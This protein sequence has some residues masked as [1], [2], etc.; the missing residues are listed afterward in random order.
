[1]SQTYSRA[2][3]VATA[4]ARQAGALLRAEFHRPGGPRGSGGHAEVDAEAERR[5]RELLLAEFPWAY[6]GEEL[7]YT[8]GASDKQIWLV[9]PHDGTSVFLR[10]RRGTA[11][12]IAALQDGVPVLGVV[13]A[14]GYP[15]DDGDLIGWAEGCGPVLR[16]GQPIVGQPASQAGGSSSPVVLLWANADAHPLT[17][18]QC[19][20]P[21]RYA[22][23]PSIAY[24]LALVAAGDAEAAV[25]VSGPLGWDYAAGHALLRGAGGVLVNQEGES[26]TYTRDGQSYARRCF[27]GAAA[28]VRSLWARDWTAMFSLVGRL[29]RPAF[30][31]TVPQADRSIADADLLKRAQGCLL[32]QLTGDSLGSRVEFQSA[33]QIAAAFPG[34]LR[35]LADGGTWGILAG[36]PT[37][38]SEL[39]LM[40]ARTLVQR[41]EF[42][43]GSVL[44]SY[45]HWYLSRPF[46]VGATTAAALA[47]ASRGTTPDERLRLAA[48]AAN[49]TSQANG[50]LMRISPLGIFAAGQPERVIEWARADS[51][52]T[53]PHPVC[54]DACAVFAA[55]LAR[56]VGAACAPR[57]AYETALE[58]AERTGAQAEVTQALQDAAHAP[59]ADFQRHQGWVLIALQ[60]AFYQLLHATSFEEGV[61][62]TVMAGGD[63]D[64]NG[65][66][67]GALLG[68][69]H[70]RPAVPKSWLRAVLACRSLSGTNTAHPRGAEFW[71]VDALELAEALLLAGTTSS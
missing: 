68:A 37:D 53:H 36:Q 42:E 35:E 15:D 32:G 65:A 69:V 54:Q 12:S 6:R 5:I 10:G 27:G 71:P 16:N 67:A 70:G 59:P 33:S 61:V 47:A 63:T 50:S 19:V 44:Q 40:L 20:Q 31:L 60:N 1:M 43:P 14:F 34:G 11:V 49:T 23:L 26:V 64:T 55:T 48:A 38:D 7:G 3:E 29:A 58:L 22:A 56:A 57:Q 24:R 17:A 52:L 13:Y 62:A 30:S 8:A 45:V 51:R 21:A 2:L 4:A 46:D 28:L 25:S 41:R 9:D 39:A 66:I 18:L